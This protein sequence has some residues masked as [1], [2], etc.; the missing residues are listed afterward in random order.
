M[1]GFAPVL[2]KMLLVKKIAE[3]FRDAFELIVEYLQGSDVDLAQD[4][5]CRHM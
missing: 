4:F 3:T 5:M 1:S 2:N